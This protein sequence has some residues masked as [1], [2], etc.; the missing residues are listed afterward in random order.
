MKL[1]RTLS[2]I[3]AAATFAVGAAST[4]GS[5]NAVSI[6]TKDTPTPS[7]AVSSEVSGD[8]TSA[9]EYIQ[10][11][12]ILHAWCWDFKTIAENMPDIAA[13]GYTAVQTS[14]ANAC[15]QDSEGTK[16]L[17][18][19][20]EN[21]RENG[22]KGAWWWQYQP[23]DWTIGNYQLGT[24]DE[25]K[26]MC[27]VARDY[28]VKIITDV[29]PNHTTPH[30]YDTDIYPNGPISSSLITA[31]GG[32]K[33]EDIYHQNGFT[34]KYSGSAFSNLSSTEQR[35]QVINYQNGGLPDI[36]TENPYFQ[37]YFI[38]YCNNLIAD[39]CDG[40][41]YDTAKHIGLPSD[42]VDPKNTKNNFWAVAA[43][44]AV[45]VGDKTVQ[46]SNS[47]D[48]FIY[49]EILGED[50]GASRFQEYTHYINITAS[51]YGSTLR[52]AV[53]NKNFDVN[54]LK[55]WHST[56]TE[57][58]IV[59]WVESH[60]TYCNDHESAG[61]TDWQI[62]MAW[63][64]IA[65]RK[66]G[67]PLFFSRPDGSN[68][69]EGNYWGNNVLGAK[70][71]DQ[72]KDPEI[73]AVNKF[74]NAMAGEEETLSNINSNKKLLKID[75]GTKGTCIINLGNTDEDIDTETTMAVG[76]YI[77]SISG[78]IFTVYANGSK[79]YIKG[80]VPAEKFV[81]VYTKT[82]VSI[83]EEHNGDS[84]F[85][86]EYGTFDV[87]LSTNTPNTSYSVIVDK[88]T[89][90]TG[91]FTNDTTITIGG[92]VDAELSSKEITVAVTAYDS[93]NNRNVNQYYTFL[94]RAESDK[95]YI[96]FDNSSYNWSS[97]YA[98]IYIDDDTKIA[99]WPG[100]QLTEKESGTGYY[101]YELP[102]K[103]RNA[104]V[105]FTQDKD[106]N[107][108]RYPAYG[109]LGLYTYGKSMLFSAN[110]SWKE[111][112]EDDVTTD[113]KQDVSSYSYVYFFNNSDWGENRIHA[114]LWNDSLGEDNGIKKYMVYSGDLHCY[115]L[116][117]DTSLGMDKVKFINDT[118]TSDNSGELK[119]YSGKMYVRNND[120]SGKWTSLEDIEQRK[121]YFDN[122]AS[123]WS[124]VK[125]YLWKAKTDVKNT[126]WPGE[127]MT[128]VDSSKKIYSY[129][130]YTVKGSEKYDK[131]IFN[132]YYVSGD[133][134]RNQTADLNIEDSSIYKSNGTKSTA[135]VA[136]NK[137]I[138]VTLN[139]YDHKVS[140]KTSDGET[141]L[142][143][144]IPVSV[145]DAN[146]DN[147]VAKAVSEFQMKNL[148]ET[149]VFH[150]SEFEYV[151]TI[152]S[153]IDSER[154]GN[155]LNYAARINPK[156]FG[157]KTSAFSGKYTE[158]GNL[159]DAKDAGIKW[160]T[161]K[162]GNNEVLPEKVLPDLSNVTNIEVWGYSMPN[163]YYVELLYPTSSSQKLGV[164]LAEDTLFTAPY[165]TG[166][167]P[168]KCYYNQLLNGNG[169]NLTSNM[170]MPEYTEG[171][172]TK[173]YI[174]D[175]WYMI[176]F[177][178]N[179]YVKVSSEEQFAC[180]VMSNIKLYAVF[181]KGTDTSAIGAASTANDVDVYNDNNVTKYRFNTMLN[182]YNYDD[183][184]NITDVAVI[185]VKLGSGVN[186]YNV[187]DIRKSLSNFGGNGTVTIG[188][189]S[190][191]YFSYTYSTSGE[192]AAATLTNKNR[193]QFML[194]LKENQINSDYSNVLV[195]T[196]FKTDSGSWTISDNCAA[197]KNGVPETV[198]N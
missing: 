6:E 123:S 73:A 184:T 82:E 92:D 158:I 35:N 51:T 129:T 77:D 160:V 22:D 154:I 3:L 132:N 7:A 130:Y 125:A 53:K 89:K 91:T 196:A 95:N 188:G 78:N 150:T 61:M 99:A 139:Y 32:T 38:T 170:K 115:Y 76:K 16:K 86:N 144:T 23:I 48:L 179:S 190:A 60:D 183:N 46:L 102:Y 43:G 15:Y 175:G 112:P 192:N 55:K 29:I 193:L 21:G 180:R 90:S 176:N 71:N 120:G 62:K 17:M 85:D 12:T 1:K 13:A 181:R 159:A 39:G 142:S 189:N 143:S 79:N 101:K 97:V 117:Y 66:G 162:N 118:D 65:A 163:S 104:R 19:L 27:K 11:G 50:V 64:V 103:Y 18:Y 168:Q 25:Y 128:L 151:K 36:N 134:N 178:D 84:V 195:F 191:N 149:Y 133:S 153:T 57:D 122:S 54:T 45:T 74:R 30:I 96:Y 197:Y 135:S 87:K 173:K 152:A 124:I 28:G 155:N 5:A 34:D 148:Y 4:V 114:Y 110:H 40:F 24:E 59:T 68:G 52:S 109:D 182:V 67:T 174:F 186:D 172:V 58:K 100:V 194:N 136:A 107:T 138:S 88:K 108:N 42:P 161:Y 37:Q 49:G 106:T 167:Q 94:K 56:L 105:M 8:S 31:L 93:K 145:S 98:Y 146:L 111:Y 166:M 187:S 80:R 70:G 20:D 131:I 198:L 147:V 141:L 137:Q 116:K 41:R 26:N 127:N 2:G 119:L 10:N 165:T 121:V 14:P 126:E 177:K 83:S 72:F 169:E 113:N 63:A 75:R 69:A 164:K 81:T 157:Y 47:S 9:K 171:D 33:L 185:Y 44:E 140:T 156:Y